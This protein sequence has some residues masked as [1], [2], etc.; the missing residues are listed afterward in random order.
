MPKRLVVCCD[1]TW[2]TPDQTS[3]GQSSPTNVTKVALSVAASAADGTVQRLYYHPGVGVN[4]RTRLR[5]GVFGVGLSANIID[6]YRFLVHE[7]EP[8]DELFFFGFSRGAFTARS[9]VGLVRNSGILRVKNA[10]RVD[11]AYTLYRDRRAHPRGVAATLFRRSYAHEPRIRFVG[12]WDTVGALGIPDT[13]LGLPRLVNRRWQFHDTTLTSQVD[14]A[15]QAL[16]IDETRRPFEPT[17]WQT[18]PHPADQVLEQV[19]F[20]GVHCDVGGGYSDTSQ[21]DIALAWL[22]G[23]AAGCGL[24]FTAD[25]FTASEPGRARPDESAFAMC[26]DPVGAIHQSRTRWYRLVRPYRRP[27][28]QA[29]TDHEAVASTAIARRDGDAVYRPVNLHAYL[30]GPRPRI[31]EVR[32]GGGDAHRPDRRPRSAA[33]RQPSDDG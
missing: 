8:G 29:D 19:W 11:E 25:V 21:S 18:P 13:G 3:Q 22:A 14:A 10:G 32:T 16:A 2:N 20:S 1:G 30:D 9:L 28:G 31:A 26:P 6:A 15:F 12:V 27:I 5:G 33:R 4:R 17:L 24:A 7:Y 23:K